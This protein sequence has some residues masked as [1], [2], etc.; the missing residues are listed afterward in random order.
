MADLNNSFSALKINQFSMSDPSKDLIVLQRA[1]WRVLSP[2]SWKVRTRVQDSGVDCLARLARH[3]SPLQ[4]LI[5]GGL[6]PAMIWH[7]V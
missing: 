1:D 4:V 3:L 7:R 2:Q 5:S 6:V